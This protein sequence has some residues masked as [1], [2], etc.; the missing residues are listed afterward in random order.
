MIEN[1]QFG[2]IKIK[3]KVFNHDVEVRRNNKVLKWRRAKSHVVDIE[4]V[5]RA[6][7]QNTEKIIIGSG[8]SGMARATEKAKEFIKGK[9]IGLMIDTTGRA[10]EIFN[11]EIKKGEKAIGLFHLTC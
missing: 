1:Y 11:E 9:G 2:E 6:V 10:V 7:E 4:S 8:E 3:G 5:K